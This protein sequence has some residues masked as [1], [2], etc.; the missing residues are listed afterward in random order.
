MDYKKITMMK[1]VLIGAACL[2]S[3]NM[4]FAQKKQ[5]SLLKGKYGDGPDSIASVGIIKN[6]TDDQDRKSVV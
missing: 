1:R 5:T 3:I 2:L 6:L 4:L